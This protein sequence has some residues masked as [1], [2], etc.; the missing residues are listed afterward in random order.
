MKRFYNI[1]KSFENKYYNDLG[2]TK[3]LETDNLNNIKIKV[4]PYEGI[5]KNIPYYITLNFPNIENN[6]FPKI[7]IDSIIYDKI[8]TSQYINNTGFNGEHKG[9]CIKN[10]S[11]PYP[12][13][14]PFIKNFKIYCDNK[15]ENYIY[16]LITM[17]NNIQDFQKGNGIKKNYMVLIS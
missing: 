13:P 9:I 5:H 1:I 12:Y 15:W 2:T 11:Y 14:Y 4:T 10:L 16:Y 6:Q 17:F 8:K 7:S 3:L